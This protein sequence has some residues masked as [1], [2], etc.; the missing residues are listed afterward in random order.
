M[1]PRDPGVVS[2][3]VNA[4][5]FSTTAKRATSPTWDP[6]PPCKQALRRKNKVIQDFESCE[7]KDYKRDLNA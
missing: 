6:P 5:H 2:L 1:S 4:S 7:H 3:H